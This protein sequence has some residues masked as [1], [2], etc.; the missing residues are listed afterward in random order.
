MMERMY[1]YFPKL[2]DMRG[3]T[4]GYLSGGEQQM[5]VIGRALMA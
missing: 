5:L 3:R 4:S 2:R 1:E